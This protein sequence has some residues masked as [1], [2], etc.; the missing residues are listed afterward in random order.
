MAKAPPGRGSAIAGAPSKRSALRFFVWVFA[1]AVPFW[2][3]GALIKTPEDFPIRLPSSGLQLICPLAAALILVCQEAG[4]AGIRNLLSR[5]F[6]YRMI[7][8]IWYVPI[9]SVMPVIYL[10]AYGVQRLLGRPLPGLEFPLLT[11]LT[12]LGVFF[13][14]SLAEEGGWTGYA[15]DPLQGQWGALGA[16]L[17]LGLVWALFHLVADLQ[18]SHDLGW[19]AWHRSGAGALRVLIAWAYNNTGKSVLAAVLVHAMDNVSWQLTPI[20]GSNY[21][22]A[23]TAPI[24]ALSAA[25]VALLWGPR[26]LARFRLATSLNRARGK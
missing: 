23:F 26:T 8:P 5:L 22:P 10:L 18:G 24:T 19:I 17:V 20:N 25:S 16:A 7:K 15:F 4:F 13:I 12:L 14:A 1:L 2:V 9:V 6:S 11:I 21:D 3:L